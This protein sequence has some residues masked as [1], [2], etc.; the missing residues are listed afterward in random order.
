MFGYYKNKLTPKESSLVLNAA[1]IILKTQSGF[2]PLQALMFCEQT[3]SNKKRI[4]DILNKM[5][6]DIKDGSLEV[7]E[8]FEFYGLLNSTESV[9]YNSSNKYAYEAL[10]SIFDE[11]K[12]SSRFEPTLVWFFVKVLIA[13]AVVVIA[14]F[15][16]ED[17]IKSELIERYLVN[18]IS[19]PQEALPFI[20][21]ESMNNLYILI[22]ISIFFAGIVFWYKKQYK[23]NRKLIYKLFPLKAYDDM[24]IMFE[25][26]KNFFKTK[27]EHTAVFQ[28]MRNLSCYSGLS[29][30]FEDL[31]ESSLDSDGTFYDIFEEHKFPKD[32][33]V[34]VQVNESGE[35]LDNLDG[36]IE[37][38]K[39]Q[40][41][42]KF[43][44]FK[45]L[46]K[47]LGTYVPLFI[48]LGAIISIS[49][50]FSSDVASITSIRR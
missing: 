44:L 30:M 33:C 11:R 34:L 1:I 47:F 37:Y 6:N 5:N 32:I 24:P 20:V 46:F 21:K 42:E 43:I 27:K 13:M 35:F 17:D 19:N 40:G 4:R 29:K 7:S 3:F 15:Y 14:V 49:L 39:E 12:Y 16:F 25:T 41:N 8:A 45:G 23:N 18:G 48:I 26:M 9:K 2:S 28:E 31:R 50:E 38:A 36:I 10:K 22:L